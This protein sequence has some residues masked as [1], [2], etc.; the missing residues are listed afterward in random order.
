MPF[1]LTGQLLDLYRTNEAIQQT[2]GTVYLIFRL[3][4]D[5]TTVETM[6]DAPYARD[7]TTTVEGGHQRFAFVDKYQTFNTRSIQA[8]DDRG[9]PLRGRAGRPGGTTNVRADNQGGGHA[10]EF[11]LRRML[12]FANDGYVPRTIEIYISRIP[13][14]DTSPMWRV[15]FGGQVI[16]FHPGCGRKLLQAVQHTPTTQWY[17][18]YGQGYARADTQASCAARIDRIDREPNAQAGHISRYL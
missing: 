5:D 6:W 17:I 7:Q 2:S 8:V 9:R 14:S 11:F 10:E 3:D 18:A 16:T 12:Q 1:R 13:C 15:N 4:D